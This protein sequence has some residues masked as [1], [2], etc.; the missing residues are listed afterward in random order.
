M[1]PNQS[2]RAYSHPKTRYR[3][4]CG[5]SHPKHLRH[6]LQESP[7]TPYFQE[8]VYGVLKGLFH[9]LPKEFDTAACIGVVMS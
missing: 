4:N 7:Q 2:F 6:Y 9:H 3:M 1:F 8:K 5:Q